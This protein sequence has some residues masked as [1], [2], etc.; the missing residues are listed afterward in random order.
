[1]FLGIRIK[2]WYFLSVA[3][4]LTGVMLFAHFSP[5][6]ALRRFEVTGPLSEGRDLSQALS[7][8][9]AANIFSLD[10]AGL[11]KKILTDRKV[12]NVSVG[13]S[14]P[15]GIVA[16]VNSYAPLALVLD[17]KLYGM[18][19]QG[20]IVPYDRA[21]NNVD[22]PVMTGLKV[23]QL[24]S[25]PRD[26]RIWS[27]IDG[28]RYASESMPELFDAISELDF[29]EPG[30]VTIFCQHD[31]ARFIASASGFGSQL[32]QMRTILNL[33]NRPNGGCYDLQ[34]DGMIIRRDQ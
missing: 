16:K 6:F 24:F 22:L 15:D 14:I 13:I 25:L 11:A 21:W 2:Y 9:S 19:N 33:K 31:Q 7:S 5:V 3:A 12:G 17:K 4:L 29:S 34:Y 28:L 8:D 32:E 10:K 1:M 18:D 27:I 26:N 23:G 30:Q 20:R